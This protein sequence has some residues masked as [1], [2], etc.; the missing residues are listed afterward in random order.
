MSITRYRSVLAINTAP[1]LAYFVTSAVAPH[2]HDFRVA[3]A[4]GRGVHI[5]VRWGPVYGVSWHGR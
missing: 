3:E 4:S 1:Q 5:R 2:Y